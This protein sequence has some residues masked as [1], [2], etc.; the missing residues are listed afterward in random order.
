MKILDIPPAVRISPAITGR[1]VF[2]VLE[3]V[4]ITKPQRKEPTAYPARIIRKAKTGNA[5]I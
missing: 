1:V 5:S 3:T 4:P 2:S